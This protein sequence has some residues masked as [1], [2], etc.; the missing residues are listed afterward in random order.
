MTETKKETIEERN[1]RIRAGPWRESLLSNR[2]AT[3]IVAV[4]ESDFGRSEYQTGLTLQWPTA[5]PEARAVYEAALHLALAAPTMRAVLQ[6]IRDAK[7]PE[8]DDPVFAWRRFAE[9]LSLAAEE[10]LEA[11][12]GK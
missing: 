12:E 4:E 6:R 5:A 7:P 9:E 3:G 2:D 11:A 10:A 1:A 8:D